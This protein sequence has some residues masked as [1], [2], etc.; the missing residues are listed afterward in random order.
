MRGLIM[1]QKGKIKKIYE[2]IKNG[3]DL[4]KNPELNG[5]KFNKTV[6][7]V[8]LVIVVLVVFGAW[9]LSGFS[10]NSN[11]VYLSC[12]ADSV[13]ACPNPYY[14]LCD[15]AYCQNEFIFPGYEWGERPNWLITNIS[16]IV[17]LI[18]VLAFLVNHFLNN[19]SYK[20]YR[21]EEDLE[22][23]RIKEREEADK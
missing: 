23:K 15:E 17:V 19:K 13:S 6:F 1:K 10:L 9:A 11:N 4:N 18:V 21:W 20:F 14:G 16:W 2:E 12:P 8:A 22:E 5:Y 7:R 3:F